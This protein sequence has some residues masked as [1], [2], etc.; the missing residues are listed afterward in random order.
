M[1]VDTNILLRIIDGPGATAYPAIRDRVET[2]LEHGGVIHV[3]AATMHEVVYVLSSH[4]TGYGFSRA[5]TTDALIALLEAG[6][7]TVEHDDVL[8]EAADTYGTTNGVDFHDCYLAALAKQ[9]ADVV[10]SLDADFNKGS[11]SREPQ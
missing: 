3:T 5:E 2:E 4:R 6:E 9:T 10:Y 11:L 8:R 1:I 7:L